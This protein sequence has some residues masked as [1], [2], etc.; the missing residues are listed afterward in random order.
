MNKESVCRRGK[1]TSTS[2][3]HRRSKPSSHP[4]RRCSLCK[5]DRKR[6]PRAS[7]EKSVFCHRLK[8]KPRHSH[9]QTSVALHCGGVFP[10]AARDRRFVYARGCLNHRGHRE[11]QRETG[12]RSSRSLMRT[13]FFVCVF[14]CALCG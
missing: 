8:S 6:D 3:G 12:N 5:S 10:A 9:R 11:S 7:I 1:S 4:S 13:S 14:L 2:C